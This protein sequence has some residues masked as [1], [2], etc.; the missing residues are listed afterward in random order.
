MRFMI[1]RTRERSKLDSEKV[2]LLSIAMLCTSLWTLCQYSAIYERLRPLQ[3]A[4]N[5]LAISPRGSD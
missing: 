4:A 3:L 1:Q 2:R 5:R